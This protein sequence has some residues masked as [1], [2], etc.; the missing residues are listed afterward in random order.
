MISKICGNVAERQRVTIQRFAGALM[1]AAGCA[2]SAMGAEAGNRISVNVVQP[3]AKVSPVLWGIFFEDINLSADGG[4][5]PE[6]VR[7]RSFED[8]GKVDPWTTVSSGSAKVSLAI[9]TGKPV[10]TKNPSALKVT[11][12]SV[13][14][15]RAGVANPGYY[16]M[17]VSKGERYELSLFARAAE[18]FTGPLTVTLESGD[19]KT[20]YAGGEVGPL[21]GEWKKYPLSLTAT[22]TDPAARLVI[23]AKQSGT[24]WLDMVSVLPATTWKGHGLRPDLCEMLAALKPAF[25]RFP[26]GC[27]VEGAKMAESYRWKQTIGDLAERRTQYNI[28]GYYATH[29][30][31]FHEYLQLSEDL[32]AEPLFCINVGMSHK[33]NVPMDKM[34]EYVQ[35]ALDAIEYANGPADSKW[36]AVR[37]KAGHPAPFNLKYLEI[38]NENGGPAYHERY[39]LF[40]DAIKAKYPEVKLIANHWAGGYPKNRPVEI[41]DEHYYNTPEFFMRNAGKYDSYDR[42]GHK[43][44]VGE[45]AV[46]KNTG[47]GSLRGAIG[48]A[49]FMTGLERNSDVVVMAAYAPLF[50]NMHHRRWNPNLIVF[51]SARAFGIP[52]YYVQKMFSEHRGTV[53]LPTEVTTV[54]VPDTQNGGAIG[55]GTWNT[56]AEFKDIKVTRGDETLFASDFTKP[57]AGWKYTGTGEWKVADGVL[58]QTSNAE[59]VLATI[60]HKKMSEPMWS[61]YTLTLKARKLGGAEGF[62]ILFNQPNKPGKSWWNLGGWGN[63]K[64]GIEADGMQ[65]TTVDGKIKTGRWYDIKIELKGGSIKC[66]LDGKLVNEATKSG[67][68][69]LYA[70]ATISEGGDEIILKTVNVAAEPQTTEIVIGGVDGVDAEGKLTVL[71]AAGPMDE[72]HIDQPAKIVPVEQPLENAAS[73]FL[74]TFPGNSVSVIRL[75]FTK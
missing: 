35:D 64:H 18:G 10:S 24:F 49:A 36:G 14:A 63:T 13:G 72:N 38:G 33:E 28:W 67:Y 37:A 43:V 53:V 73:N 66:Y 69:A 59:K 68:K 54:E 9:D 55:V 40:H 52:S 19:G 34:D 62:L 16:G 15:E 21:D 20:I 29:S 8:G 4:I 26:G 7:N 51:D 6:R 5:Y 58:R 30:L 31:G 60:G 61:D 75:K 47:E 11:L 46:T 2:S 25:M 32:G 39:A 3:G 27:W 65:T 57:A 50:V 12:E 70:S 71:T 45:Y 42:A 74:H 44:F 56:Q 17:S 41:V 23:S 22:D 1:L 48:E